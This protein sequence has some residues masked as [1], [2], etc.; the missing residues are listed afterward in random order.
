MYFMLSAA[1]ERFKYLK[2]GLSAVLIL[3]G[4]KII[5]NFGLY[6]G[7]KDLYGSPLVPYL[8]PQW[9]LIATLT[10]LGGAIGYSLW[11]TRHEQGHNARP[12][13]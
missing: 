4:V 1:V 11:K 2:Y 8:E 5:W 10:L 12:A 6:K 9:S 3:I 13:A 7:W